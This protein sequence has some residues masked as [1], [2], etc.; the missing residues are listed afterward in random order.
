M[1]YRFVGSRRKSIDLDDMFSGACFLVGGSPQLEDIDIDLF[2]YKGI[3]SMAMNNTATLFTPTMWI[4]ADT[5]DKYSNSILLDPAITKFNYITRVTNKI[6]GETLWRDV[7]NSIFL[8]SKDINPRAFF[9][10]S[11]DFVWWHNV[12]MLALQVLHRLGFRKVYA[13]GCGFKI[14]QE[15]QYAHES[16]LNDKQVDY[17]QRTYDMVIRQFK[18]VMK[19]ADGFEVVSCTPDS[20]INDFVDYEPF[21]D[22]IKRENAK[23]PKNDTI[24]VKHPLP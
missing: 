6:G 19:H 2:K 18:D 24:N 8:S 1:F 13:V 7:P 11:R 9:N 3:V 22:A 14:S 12:F 20:R 23:I 21:E 16:N 10:K 15:E 4:G 17:N 5:E